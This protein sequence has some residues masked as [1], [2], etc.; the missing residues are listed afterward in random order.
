[1]EG[2]DVAVGS[3]YVAGGGNVN[4]PWDRVMLS[5]GGSIYTKL[6]TW[7][8]VLISRVMKLCAVVRIRTVTALPIKMTVARMLQE[9]R[10]YAVV[11]MVMQTV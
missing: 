8:P 7:M 11:L 10:R 5:K 2:A 9:H 3:R 1:M 6:I 4:W